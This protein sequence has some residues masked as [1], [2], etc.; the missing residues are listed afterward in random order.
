M[1]RFASRDLCPPISRAKRTL[2]SRRAGAKSAAA[3]VTGQ[4]RRRLCAARLFDKAPIISAR[5]SA[6]TKSSARNLGRARLWPMGEL[7]A[8]P[9]YDVYNMSLA[10]EYMFKQ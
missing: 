9:E 6:P 1:T 8:T 7:Y 5:L 4:Y 3:L 2:G 10:E